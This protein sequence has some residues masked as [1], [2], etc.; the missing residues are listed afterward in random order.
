MKLYLIQHYNIIEIFNYKI[1][2]N[3][4]ILKYDLNNCLGISLKFWIQNCI[5]K[6][7]NKLY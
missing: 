5:E 3:Y 2:L 4:L 1:S 6:N 7:N